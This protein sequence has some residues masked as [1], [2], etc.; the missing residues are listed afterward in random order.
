MFTTAP[1]AQT[2]PKNVLPK[3]LFGAIEALKK[4]MNAVILAH[5]Y[6]DADIQDIADYLGDSLGLAQQAA[7]TDADVIVF[8]GVHFMAET[9]KILN[10]TKLVLLPD[11]DAGCSLADSC[12]PDKFADFKRQHPDHLVISYIN[13]TA[14]IKAMSDIICTSSNAVKIV[15]QLPTDQPIIFAPDRNLGRYVMEQTGLDMVL[16]QGSCIVHET[17]SEKKLVDLMIKYPNAEVIAHPECEPPLLKYANYIASTTGLLNY[18]QKSD[19]NQFIVL[20]ES[21]IIHQMQK[22]S[23]NKHFIPAPPIANCACNECP[24]MRLNTLEKL[25]L[26]MLNKT[27]EITMDEATRSAALRPMQRML[28]MS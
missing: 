11:L 17:F 3:D 21:G 8:A 10:P 12:P 22:K 26:A 28:E 24:Y 23:P 13:C 9:A 6:Q 16:W 5:Y 7:Q 27:P 2:G 20:T 19:R 1:T 15:Q 4:E 14:D 25:Y 18:S